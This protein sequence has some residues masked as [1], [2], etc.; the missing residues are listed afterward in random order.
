M[1]ET[2]TGCRDH[3]LEAH[4][5]LGF[6][7]GQV[8]D[9]FNIFMNTGIDDRGRPTIGLP[10][11]RAGDDVELRAEMDLIVAVSSCADDLSDSETDM[12]PSAPPH[13]LLQ[14]LTGHAE[15]PASEDVGNE[16]GGRCRGLLGR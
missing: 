11:S 3:L 13:G 10:K 2:K 6:E 12:T 7:L 8:T 9:T 15:V 16:R 1:S 5:P 4:E 14:P